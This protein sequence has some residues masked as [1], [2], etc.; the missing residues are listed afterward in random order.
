VNSEA[1]Q[2]YLAGTAVITYRRRCGAHLGCGVGMWK[3][4]TLYVV[5][6]MSC[7]SRVTTCGR[8]MASGDAGAV[9]VAANRWTP[10]YTLRYIALITIDV[11]VV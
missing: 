9:I 3:A 8:N 6:Q 5:D 10:Y 11:T 7:S 1:L 4:W 2:C